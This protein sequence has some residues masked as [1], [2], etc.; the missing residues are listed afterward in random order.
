MPLKRYTLPEVLGAL[1]TAERGGRL[2]AHDSLV[3][4][5]EVA[6]MRLQ[7]TTARVCPE[8]AIQMYRPRGA[9]DWQCWH[10]TEGLALR[11]ALLEVRAQL[12]RMRDELLPA[13][14]SLA[15]V[16]S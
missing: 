10:C 16:Q 14:L 13:G 6:A 2:D 9:S 15:K 12:A 7:Y 11:S 5:G 4:A 8:H 3:L 1:E